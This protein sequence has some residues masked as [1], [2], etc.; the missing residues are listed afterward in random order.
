[1]N[2]EKYVLKITS[3]IEITIFYL[4]IRIYKKIKL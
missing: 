2:N 4:L 3:L 1:M